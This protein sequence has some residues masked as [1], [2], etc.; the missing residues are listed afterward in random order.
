MRKDFYTAS[1]ALIG[2]TV[3]S[4]STVVGVREDVYDS[5]GLYLGYTDDSGTYNEGGGKVSSSKAPGL[6]FPSL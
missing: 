3:E 4:G 5:N 6:L 2:Y 1:N